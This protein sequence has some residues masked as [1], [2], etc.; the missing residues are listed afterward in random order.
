MTLGVEH[1]DKGD[2]F[3]EIDDAQIRF[4]TST[5]NLLIKNATGE[6]AT[7]D[8]VAVID[9]SVGGQVKFSKA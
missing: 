2:F 8:H 4:L 6:S 1:L 5:I 9:N 7:S 3:V